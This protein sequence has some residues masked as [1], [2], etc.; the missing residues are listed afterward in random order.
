MRLKQVAA[1]FG[2]VMIMIA[3]CSKPGS[4]SKDSSKT[5]NNNPNLYQA[6]SPKEIPTA[7]DL[8]P[9]PEKVGDIA[10]QARIRSE[11]YQKIQ[12]PTTGI[13][14]VIR[15][16]KIRLIQQDALKQ[17]EMLRRIKD[18]QQLSK[19]ALDDVRRAEEYIKKTQTP[20]KFKIP[21]VPT[22]KQPIP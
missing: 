7:S 22:D 16:E 21:T 2:C 17:Q 13:D 10:D 14:E 1:I 19:N 5:S 20:I 4:K 12:T 6:Q 15:I 18:Q 8:S 3:G 11:I 9:S